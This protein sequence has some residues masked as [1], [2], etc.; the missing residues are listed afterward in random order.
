MSSVDAK[1]RITRPIQRYRTIGLNNGLTRYRQEPMH[2]DFLSE[3]DW[4]RNRMAG[5]ND[6]SLPVELI[7]TQS[8]HFTVKMTATVEAG[9][10][11]IFVYLQRRKSEKEEQNLVDVSVRYKEVY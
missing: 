8:M 4:Y 9:R 10:T 5:Y 11:S 6:I 2:W 3:S 7:A 1:A